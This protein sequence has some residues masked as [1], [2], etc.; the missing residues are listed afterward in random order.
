MRRATLC[1]AAF[2]FVWGALNARAEDV[3][4]P[5]DTPLVWPAGVTRKSAQKDRHGRFHPPWTSV[6]VSAVFPRPVNVGDTVTVLPLRR[7]VPVQELRVATVKHQPAVDE[8]PATW[9]VH[10]DANNESFLTAKHERNWREDTP[11][12]VVVVH[13]AAP[14]ARLLALSSRELPKAKGASP[15]TLWAAVDLHGDGKA[16]AV[17]FRFCCNKPTAPWGPAGPPACKS[18][19][20]RIFLREDDQPWRIV[21]EEEDF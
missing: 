18:H 20:E 4:Y 9:L 8:F 1:S 6:T 21:H 5:T 2:L 17:V 3:K 14:T 19:C 12:E 15:R 16:D 7:D 13:P 10:L 11:F